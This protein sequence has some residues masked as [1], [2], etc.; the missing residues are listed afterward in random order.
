LEP[1]FRDQYLCFR[2]FIPHTDI[3]VKS[4]NDEEMD[5]FISGDQVLL[6]NSKSLNK[7]GIL[8]QVTLLVKVPLDLKLAQD[9]C[10]YDVRINILRACLNL[11]KKV[12]RSITKFLVC[13][14][15]TKVIISRIK[16]LIIKLHYQDEL[17]TMM[18][19]P[20]GTTGVETLYKSSDSYNYENILD[21]D[22][23]KRLKV[24][25]E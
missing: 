3:N 15:T 23:H 22:I 14:D 21:E 13:L 24:V 18:Q 10:H 6:Q 12:A 1:D 4:L 19:Q 16:R 17:L 7:Q 20:R 11:N 25:I 2:V 5:L 9:F 8:K